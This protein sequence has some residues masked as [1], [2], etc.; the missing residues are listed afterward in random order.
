MVIGIVFTMS[1]L[2]IIYAVKKC[3]YLM[4]DRLQE[5]D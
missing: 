5:K 1:V 2:L 4:I 3:C